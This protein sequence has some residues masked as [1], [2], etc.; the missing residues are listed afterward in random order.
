MSSVQV[1]PD[2]EHNRV[3]LANVHPEDWPLIN[4]EGR[5]NLVVI[6]AGPAGLVAALGAAGLGAKVALIEKHLLGGDCL[7]LGCV[8]SKA[9]IRAAHAAHAVKAGAE[10]GVHAGDVTVD[11]GLAMGRMR[12][13]R[14]D[15][16]H[17]DSAERMKREGIDVFIGAGKFTGSNTVEVNGVS[18]EFSRAVIATGARA[19]VPPI[20]GLRETGVRTNETLFE[21][22]ELPPRLIV[23]GAGPIGGEMAQS[24]AR[25]GSKVTLIDMADRVL[26]REEPDASAI[27]QAQFVE[28]GVQLA[29]GATVLR[30]EMDGEDRVT[31]VDRGNGEERY[32]ADEILLAIGRQANLE[33]LG[34]KA[35][36]VNVH[37]RGIEVNDYLQTSNGA[38]YACGDVASEYQFT[39]SADHMA[40]IVIRNALFFGRAK[41]SKLVIPWATYTSPEVSHVGISHAEAA[42]RSD[43]TAF[44]VSIGETDRGRADGETEGYCR[45]YADR[46]GKIYG[47][48]IVA[49]HAGDLLAEVTLAMTH[50]LTLGKIAS[51]IHP[52][53]T[54]SEVI[55]KVASEWNRTRL[56]PSVKG[57]MKWLLAMR[58]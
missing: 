26:P 40:R 32:A 10:F 58:R 41:A 44:T 19:M 33:N 49:E 55:F 35:A 24:F 46:K 4:P 42:K 50:G 9:V 11:F 38:I 14:A 18:L 20:P 3:L 54:Q 15:I 45:I 53:P 6:G 27:V 51:T 8:P 43:L 12:K 2:D 1:L 22:T 31:V 13:I 34:L 21:L 17:H 56:T 37:K 48:T 39:H 36:G 30:F 29:L 16:S 28:D 7:N 52:Y 47:A 5:Y 25:L 57:W 23:I